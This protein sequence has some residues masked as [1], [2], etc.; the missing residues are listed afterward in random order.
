MNQKVKAMLALTLL[1]ANAVPAAMSAKPEAKPEMASTAQAKWTVA[2]KPEAKPE[3]AF[4]AQAK[5]M[6]AAKPEAKPEVG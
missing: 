5:W 4:T 3:M 6:V 1:G 2:A